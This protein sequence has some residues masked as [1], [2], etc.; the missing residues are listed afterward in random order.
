MHTTFLS[1]ALAGAM[2]LPTLALAA[3]PSTDFGTPTA[4]TP[5]PTTLH[6]LQSSAG[7]TFTMAEYTV[8]TAHAVPHI[9]AIDQNDAVWFSESGGRFAR[10]FIDVP[11]QSKIGRID[12][13]GT[14][15][16]WYLGDAETSPM[17]IEFD[18]A[19]DLWITERLANRITRFKRDGQK[20]H[21]QVPTPGAWPTGLAIDPAGDV[22]FTGTKADKIGVVRIKTGQVE[23]FALPA[24]A[25]MSTGIAASPDGTIWIAER[26]VNIIGKFD[27]K[28]ATFT[29]Y[30]LSTPSARPCGVT[31]D[32]TGTVWFTERG[33]GKL[34][35]ILADGTVQE[36][37]LENRQAGPFIIV[38]DQF[39][40]MWF[41]ELFA[42]SIG[43]FDPATGQ[44]EHFPI[45]GDNAHPA[46]LAI[47][48]KGNV[49]FAQQSTNK[50]ATIIRA[51]LGYVG[52]EQRV[53]QASPADPVADALKGYRYDPME[54]P[55]TDSLPGIVNID[56][57]GTVWFTQMGGGFVG[58]GF[59]PGPAG[60]KVGYVRDGKL[61]ELAMP[62]PESGP[63]SLGLDP[64]NDDVWVS[65]RAANKIARIRND[66]VTEFTVPV[67]DSLPVGVAVDS[68]HNVWVALSDGNALARMT[69]EGEW[70][71]LPLP[72]PNLAPRT[73]FV[74]HEDLVWFA[75]KQGNHVGLVDQQKWRVDRWKIPTR[76]AWPL[77]IVEDEKGDIWFAQMRSDKLGVLDRHTKQIREYAMPVNSAPFKLSYDAGNHAM[78]VSTVFGNAVMRF[79]IPKGEVVARYPVPQDGVW[80]GGI[81]RDA[82][83]CFWITEQF[84]NRVDRLC[85]DGVSKPLRAAKAD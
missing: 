71:V 76:M 63:T 64:V 1:L 6:R 67:P 85:I 20:V 77:S 22:W 2:L 26:D 83:S 70:R 65:L 19:G 62:T 46:G 21:Y 53:S 5:A 72:A 18:K 69:A 4:V 61:H 14:M 29:Q 36:F 57:R 47:D 15:S 27:P 84:G 34:G 59:P 24:K 10:N 32:K 54:I 43:R 78:W 11:A 80:V 17:G 66:Q 35:R 23:E 16:E 68:K 81:D 13:G 39:G 73:V 44:F 8:P 55:T 12:V 38:A 28:T 56:K 58:P 42:N 31:V 40:Q 48:S 51:D 45:R 82:D 9:L 37:A 49:W 33:A 3:A 25:T 41:S 74:D 52:G 75:E 79:D 60:S 30:K 7:K 50:L